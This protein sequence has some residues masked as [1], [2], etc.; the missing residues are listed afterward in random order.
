MQKSAPKGIKGESQSKSGAVEPSAT[1]PIE[2][3]LLEDM[4]AKMDSMKD[5]IGNVEKKLLKH[6]EILTNDLDEER[7]QRATLLIEV[8][9]LKKRVAIL[10]GR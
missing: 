5:Q 3:S 6:I 4:K 7:K 2:S 8:D 9:R 1:P 10:E